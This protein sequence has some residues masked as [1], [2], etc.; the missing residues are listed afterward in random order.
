MTSTNEGKYAINDSASGL[1]HFNEKLLVKRLGND[2]GLGAT[3]L[4]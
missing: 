4:T 1:Q 3:L 2:E